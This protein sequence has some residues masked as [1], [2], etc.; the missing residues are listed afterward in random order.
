MTISLGLHHV[1]TT[2]RSGIGRQSRSRLEILHSVILYHPSPYSKTKSLFCLMP[3]GAPMNLFEKTRRKYGHNRDLQAIPQTAEHVHLSID[4]WP[5]P[6]ARLP[7]RPRAVK[8]ERSKSGHRKSISTEMSLS[9]QGNFFIATNPPLYKTTRNKSCLYK[10]HCCGGFASKPR[11]PAAA[12]RNYMYVSFKTSTLESS[13]IRAISTS[14]CPDS[15]FSRCR[16]LFR[17]EFFTRHTLLLLFYCNLLLIYIMLWVVGTKMI[18]DPWAQT[19]KKLLTNVSLSVS[20]APADPQPIQCHA[21]AKQTLLALLLEFFSRAMLLVGEI[22][23]TC[24]TF[25]I[26]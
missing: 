9:P 23:D 26:L 4:P 7:P 1:N 8:M 17:F 3:S 21:P 14:I 12:V 10:S 6:V 24:K 11:P 25:V 2:V 19:H 20:W 22:D 16:L 13:F 18:H 15:R 5:T